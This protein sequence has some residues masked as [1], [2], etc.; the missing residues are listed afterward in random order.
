LHV[1][2]M[3]KK[4]VHEG[5]REPWRLSDIC[6]QNQKENTLIDNRNLRELSTAELERR[7]FLLLTT[8]VIQH[9]LKCVTR[10]NTVLTCFFVLTVLHFAFLS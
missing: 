2:R 3:H 4:M 5:V 10:L 7:L 8:K 9:D 1:S 6:L